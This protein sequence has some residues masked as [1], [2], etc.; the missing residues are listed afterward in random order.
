MT[1]K[2]TTKGTGALTRCGLI[3][4]LSQSVTSSDRF[5]LQML[6]IKMK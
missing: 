2:I 1:W 5:W 4:L 6:Q 3:P